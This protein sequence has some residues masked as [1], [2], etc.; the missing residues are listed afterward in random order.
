MKISLIL[1]TTVIMMTIVIGLMFGA[2]SAL[3]ATNAQSDVFFPSPTYLPISDDFSYTQ[4]VISYSND[5]IIFDD[6]S[7]DGFTITEFTYVTQYPAGLEFSAV[8]TP[9]EDVTIASVNLIYRFPAGTQGRAPATFEDGVW[10]ATPY[11]T[12]GL[13]PWMTMNVFWRVAYGDTG[14][15][16]TE[17]EHVQYIDHTREWYRAESD[18]VIVYWF[19]FTEDFGQVVTEAFVHVRGRY[20]E[21]F[22]EVLPFK[23]T[24]VIFPPGD[25]LGEFR[26]GGQINPRTT[27]FANSDSYA[28]VLRVRGL[29]IEDIRQECIWNEPRSVEWQ[30]RYSASVATHE[31]AH[32]YQYANGVA[33]RSPAWWVEGQA[34]YLELEMGP[35]DERLRNLSDMGEDLGTLQ[36]QGPSGMVGT[37][38]VDGCTHLGYE[39]GASFINWMVNNF[40]ADAHAQIVELVASNTILGD[41]IEIATGRPLADL[42]REWRAYVGLNSDPVIPPTQAFQFPPTSTPFGQ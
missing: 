14:L 1:G 9:P 22:G 4:E 21:T 26:A 13:P 25:L 28:A 27:G 16:E 18:D 34:T 36:G 24:V 39:M 40:G 17:P 7:I 31:V 37:A 30:M 3:P 6:Q 20:I 33:G 12:R 5:P 23:P 19:D 38:A 41:A 2:S 11:D 29:E 35:V 8:I 42:E 15:I 32:L 10:S